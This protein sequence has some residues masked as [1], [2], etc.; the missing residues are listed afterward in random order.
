MILKYRRLSPMA[1][2]PKYSIEGDAGFDLVS[3]EHK[4]IYP[5]EHK[6]VKTGLSV[7]FPSGYRLEVCPR[8]GLGLKEGVT[9]MNTPG[10]V[11][12]T[13]RG[14]IGVIIHVPY[15]RKGFFRLLKEALFPGRYKEKP[16]VIRPGDRIA[17][18]V[19]SPVTTVE[20]FKEVE[21]LSETERGSGGFGSTGF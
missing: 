13:Y 21:E 16:F 15:K 3:V 10:Q 14:E 2:H 7:E 6:L 20:E 12:Y 18:A 9:I 5:G 19:I 1:K 11:E 17:Q 4:T 8:S